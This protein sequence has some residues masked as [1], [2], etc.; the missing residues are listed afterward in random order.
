MAGKTE[1]QV[2]V[3]QCKHRQRC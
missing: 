2:L 3:K 1:C